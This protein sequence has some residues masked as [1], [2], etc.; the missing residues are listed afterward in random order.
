V[1]TRDLLDGLRRDHDVVVV[2]AA[3]VLVASDASVLAAACDVCL[4]VVRWGR[5]RSAD[6]VEAVDA[7]VGVRAVLLGAVLT[8]VPGR[9]LHA[10][11]TRRRYRPDPGRRAGPRPTPSPTTP[12][13]ATGGRPS[14]WRSA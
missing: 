6:L 10:A 3:P 1:D 12:T 5:T 11:A 7:L 13:T 9:A 4:L 14:P 2:D 8:R